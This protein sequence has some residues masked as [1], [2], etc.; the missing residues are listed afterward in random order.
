MKMF[1][2]IKGLQ[3]TELMNIITLDDF[4]TCSKRLIQSAGGS[5]FQL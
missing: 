5:T 3:S 2:Y 4:V 1:V